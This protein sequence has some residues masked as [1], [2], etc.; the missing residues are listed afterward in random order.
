MLLRAEKISGGYGSKIVCRDIDFSLESGEVLCVAGPNG[1]GK[2]TLFRL[3]LGFNPLSSGRVLLN[4]VPMTELTAK[5]VASTLAYIPQNHDPVFSYTVLELVLMGRVSHFSAFSVPKAVDERKAMECL[6][7]LG[8]GD[9][10]EADYTRLSG[11]QRQLALIARALAQEAQV[12]IMDEP[13]SALDYAN[14]RIILDTVEELRRQGYGVIMS[15]HSMDTPFACADK[16]LLLKEGRVFACGSP[17]NTLTPANLEQV[18]GLPMDV[19]QV[20]DRFD[21]PRRVC[22]PMRR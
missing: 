22:L 2:S 17:E 6:E 1:C 12:L 19:V 5:D 16:V 4:G 13:A 14:G 15:T 21:R 11:G 7:R 8:I 3:L 9:L 18:Y 10:A 20:R